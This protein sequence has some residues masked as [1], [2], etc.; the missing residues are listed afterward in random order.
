MRKRVKKALCIIFVLCVLTS[1]LGAAAQNAPAP[2]IQAIQA[3]RICAITAG[4]TIT[5]S[6]YATCTSSL[7]M[8]YSTDTATLYMYLQRQN[9]SSWETVNSWTTS[10]SYYIAQTANT[11]VTKGT[12]RVYA[13]GYVYTDGVLVDSSSIYS[14]P[15]T[16]K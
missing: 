11:Y 14:Y 5:T 2:S 3:T 9:G 4:L 7:D 6:G 13:V 16:Y 15:A 10:G 1:S 8:V 12:Y